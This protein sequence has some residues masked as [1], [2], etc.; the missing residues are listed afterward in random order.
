MLTRRRFLGYGAASMLAAATGCR[1]KQFESG[2]NT[3]IGTSARRSLADRKQLAKSKNLLLGYPINMNTP[4][5]AFFAW[6]RELFDTGLGR[7]AYNNVGDPFKASPI[8]FNSHDF[9]RELIL[10]F[11]KIYAFPAHDTW[12]FLSHS[13]TDSNMHGMYMGR[14]ILQ[15]RTGLLP[16]AYF[17]REAHYSVQIL[18]DLLGMEGIEVG[19]T[20]D[21]A[22]DPDD[23]SQ[24]L[25]EHDS[26]PA[27]VVATIGTTFKG[28]I[29]PI[30]RIQEALSGHPS[31]LHLDAALFGG[32]LPHTKHAAV[33]A[34]QSANQ[35]ANLRY[36]AIAVS[37]HK[38]FGFPSPAGLFITSASH[39]EEFNRYFSKIHNPEYIHHVPGTITCSRDAVKP[40]EFYFFAQP[41]AL[42]GMTT[43]A[44]SMLQNT[45]YLLTQ[46]QTRFAQLQPTRANPLSNTLYFRKPGERIIEKYSLATMQL[47]VAGQTQDYAH[48]VVMPH[49]GQ[50]VLEEFM[51]DLSS[52]QS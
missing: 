33:V 18:R 10:T 49:V 50:S 35:P 13:G 6:R 4:P 32:Y 16:K 26:H 46:M 11:G 45:D 34:C 25:S 29:D 41:S 15:G 40:A 22:M 14:T 17:T 36:D 47:S 23:L 2:G 52:K 39:F 51:H 44:N 30:D 12:G 19:T 48:V 27:L 38:F 8:P 21:G 5:D 24:K 31:F 1:P 28:A 9:E 20:T 43:D 42:A 3:E 7:F 37:C